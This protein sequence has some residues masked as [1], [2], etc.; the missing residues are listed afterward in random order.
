MTDTVL[1][2]PTEYTVYF[3]DSNRAPETVQVEDD[4][5]IEGKETVFYVR[6]AAGVTERVAFLTTEI[7][8]IVPR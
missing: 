2:V 8:Q 4:W 6:T 1:F 3:M 7:A 5:D